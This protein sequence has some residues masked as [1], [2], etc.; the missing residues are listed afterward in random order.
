[1]FNGLVQATFIG[2]RVSKPAMGDCKT[3]IQLKCVFQCIDC[4]IVLTSRQVNPANCEV[5]V[6]VLIIEFDGAFRGSKGFIHNPLIW[7][8]IEINHAQDDRVGEP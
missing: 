4:Q 1:M 8:G 7:R 5:T 2:E 3:G 6:G